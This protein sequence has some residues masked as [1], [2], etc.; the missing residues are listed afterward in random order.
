MKEE[1]QNSTLKRF[2]LAILEKNSASNEMLEVLLKNE[3]LTWFI[4]NLNNSDT[5]EEYSAFFANYS[6][7]FLLNSVVFLHNN[8]G[9][10]KEFVPGGAEFVSF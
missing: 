8:E 10:F 3:V 4:M 9:N 2:A 7:A 1:P 6:T 5:N